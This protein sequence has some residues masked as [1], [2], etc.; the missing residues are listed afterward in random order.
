MGFILKDILKFRLSTKKSLAELYN[1]ETMP[2]ELLELHQRNDA[3]VESCY[4]DKTFASDEER[5]SFLLG[6][7]NQ[8]IQ[9]LD[10]NKKSSKSKK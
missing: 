9:E 8:K 2:A 10:A 1:P 3:L 5:L 7:Y 4:R 6:I